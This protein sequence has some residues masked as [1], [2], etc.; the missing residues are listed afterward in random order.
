VLVKSLVAASLLF[1]T[2]MTQASLIEYN[3]YSRADSS[4]IVSGGGLEWLKWDVTTGM[5]LTTAVDL[6]AAGGWRL[7][8]NANIISLFNAFK[9][10]EDDWSDDEYTNQSTWGPMP[11]P[12]ADPMD[13]IVELFGRTDVGQGCPSTIDD[14]VLCY[15][16]LDPQSQINV[17]FD[18]DANNDKFYDTLHV[19]SP[20]SLIDS[21]ADRIYTV[22]GR[23]SINR[24]RAISWLDQSGT[25]VALVR[26]IGTVTP[27]PV[28]TPGSLSLLVLALVSIVSLRRRQRARA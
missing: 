26:D 19:L 15:S 20:Y 11:G 9:F 14:R 12:F 24:N 28:S 13:K 6:Y 17:I 18:G 23:A 2:C 3:G 22:D 5:S 4:S 25:G 27:Q 7:A 1:T 8:S 10:K 16:E 21:E